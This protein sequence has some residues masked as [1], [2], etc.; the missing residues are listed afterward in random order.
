MSNQ[1][2]YQN[3]RGIVTTPQCTANKVEPLHPID[4]DHAAL[5]KALQEIDQLTATLRAKLITVLVPH[6][7]P[8]EGK[9][10]ALKPE[11]DVCEERLKIR[12]H[13][14]LTNMLCIK[15]HHLIEEVD[16]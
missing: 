6:P 5:S 16:I 2:V 3:P 8:A 13:A 11:P 4:E 12:G 7:R 9:D 10:A 15:L 14:A 1:P